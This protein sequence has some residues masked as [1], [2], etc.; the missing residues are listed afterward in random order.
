[1]QVENFDVYQNLTNGR[2]IENQFF[3]KLWRNAGIKVKSKFNH[4]FF[5]KFNDGKKY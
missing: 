1:M 5:D 2:I 4:T 3:T